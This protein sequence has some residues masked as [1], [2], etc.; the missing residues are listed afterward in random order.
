MC[1]YAASEGSARIFDE[2]TE[3]M[4]L[5]LPDGLLFRRI[6]EIADVDSVP[7]SDE[8]LDLDAISATSVG[9]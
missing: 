7:P 5:L 1:T 6:A 4:Q 3:S 9:D 2:H 8:G